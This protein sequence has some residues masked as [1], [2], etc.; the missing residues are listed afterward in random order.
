[1]FVFFIT[2]YFLGGH[3]VDKLFNVIHFGYPFK[4]HILFYRY[5]NFYELHCFLVFTGGSAAGSGEE[6]G[7]G[8]EG[9][10]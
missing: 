5:C 3:F 7:S 10:S 9:T 1:M 2:I 4:N 8:E 6:S